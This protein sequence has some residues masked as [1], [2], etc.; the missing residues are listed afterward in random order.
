[1]LENA[2]S[3]WPWW[4]QVDIKPPMTVEEAMKWVEDRAKAKL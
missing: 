3:A 1:M 4:K 2:P